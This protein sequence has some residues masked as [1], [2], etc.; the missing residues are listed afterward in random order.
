M[1]PR[2]SCKLQR[3]LDFG[4]LLPT[5]NHLPPSTSNSPLI[6]HNDT[7]ASS[8][9]GLK[10]IE[11]PAVECSLVLD[12]GSGAL[13]RASSVSN[14][15][16]SH[17]VQECSEAKK[18]HVAENMEPHCIGVLTTN[19]DSLICTEFCE[20][21]S[22]SNERSRHDHSSITCVQAGN[23]VIKN[24]IVPSQALLERDELGAD[25]TRVPNNRAR[26]FHRD[27]CM[28]MSEGDLHTH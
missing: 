14:R 8:L 16:K 12:I 7:P 4:N 22:D 17:H 28:Y 10:E 24:E 3:S 18:Q 25:S 26:A 27:F 13:T 15:T 1:T 5:C 23:I 11:S 21:I 19:Q 20:T 2:T 6:Q 9:T